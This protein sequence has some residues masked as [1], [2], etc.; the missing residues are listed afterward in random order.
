MNTQV[1]HKKTIIIYITK[2]ENYYRFGPYVGGFS[3]SYYEPNCSRQ[4]IDKVEY[5]IPEGYV[6]A[7]SYA[8]DCYLYNANGEYCPICY[9]IKANSVF[10]IDIDRKDYKVNLRKVRDI[11]WS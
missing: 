6:Y 5:V 1:A 9:D 11:P 7:E 2:G 4:W 10:L 3:C 8:D